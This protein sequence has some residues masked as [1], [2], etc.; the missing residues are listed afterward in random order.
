MKKISLTQGKFALV[1]DEDFN[2][3][4]QFKWYCSSNGYAVR[5]VGNK[6]SKVHYAMHRVVNKTLED[7]QTDHINRNSLDNRK[8]N[9]RTVTPS[10]NGI[11]KGLAKNNKSG[12]KGINWRENIQKWQALIW[13]DNKTI[14]L[15]CHLRLE[16]AINVR[17]KAELIYHT[18]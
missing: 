14:Y 17:K 6:K 3:L 16:D 4:N 5:D 8:L 10:Q 1:D 13:L 15:G 7:F 11:N 2:Y 12:Y 18:I 9:L